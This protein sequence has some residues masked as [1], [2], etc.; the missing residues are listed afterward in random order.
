VL[1]ARFEGLD[2]VKPHR[3][4]PP[5]PIALEENQTVRSDDPR[6]I[7]VFRTNKA[8]RSSPPQAAK[9]AD[10]APALRGA[11]LA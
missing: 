6:L 1:I 2:R 4:H 11:G 10:S 7:E 8:G 3:I 5:V 9:P